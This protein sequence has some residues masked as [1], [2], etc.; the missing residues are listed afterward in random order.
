MGA[1]LMREAL[2]T[3]PGSVVLGA[4]VRARGFYE[5][6]GFAVSGPEY[7]EDGIPHVPM[8][9]GPTGVLQVRGGSSMVC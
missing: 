4:Q 7:D 9:R 5:R 6:L 1:S 8:L 3:L 2:A